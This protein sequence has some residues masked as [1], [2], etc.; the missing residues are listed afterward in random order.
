MK[1]E[2]YFSSAEN[3]FSGEN[4]ANKTIIYQYQDFILKTDECLNEP[5]PSQSNQFSSPPDPN[6][7]K[8]P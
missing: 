5:T 6:D 4:F 1:D 3:D 7:K 2:V 8:N